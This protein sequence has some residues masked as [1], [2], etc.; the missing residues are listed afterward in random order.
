M[1]RI[2]GTNLAQEAAMDPDVTTGTRKRLT[3]L[4]AAALRDIGWSINEPPPPNFLPADF[5]QDGAVNV[6][7]LSLWKSAFHATT[8]GNAD[9]DADS[10]GN[11]FLLWQRTLGQSSLIAAGSGVPEPT[12]AALAA[13][14]AA[15]MASRRRPR[16]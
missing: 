8:V 16:R 9:G 14:Y 5:N 13:C 10:D 3:S 12:G 6:A 11:D 15:W 2:F 4:D 7:D 1:S